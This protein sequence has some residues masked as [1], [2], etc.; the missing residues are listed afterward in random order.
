MILLLFYLSF[1]LVRLPPLLLPLGITTNIVFRVI[2][3]GSFFIL[4]FIKKVQI[5]ISKFIFFSSIFL[6]SQILSVINAI[7]ITNFLYFAEKIV[8]I[9]AFLFISQILLKKENVSKV[10][11][12]ILITLYLN[13][14]IE[15]ILFFS[16]QLTQ[17]LYQIIHP[18]IIHMLSYNL[19]QRNRLFFETS[20]EIFFPLILYFYFFKKEVFQKKIP[21]TFLFMSIFI[22]SFWSNFRDRFVTGIFSILS[23]IYLYK[24]ELKKIK[25]TKIVW[26]LAIFMTIFIIGLAYS[27]A[28][29]G[30]SIVDRIFLQNKQEDVDTL[31]FRGVLASQSIKMFLANPVFGVGLGN[32]YE[33]IPES[34][35]IQRFNFFGDSRVFYEG[36]LLYP[37][38][39]ILQI[40]AETGSVGLFGFMILIIYFI[41][42]DLNII[43]SNQPLAK[44]LIICFWSLLLYALFSPKSPLL[45]YFQFFLLRSLI[46]LVATEF[47]ERN[48]HKRAS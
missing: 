16:P 24:N 39:F 21:L 11:K 15:M 35:K 23:F 18:A 5:K 27:N 22:L 4:I 9:F 17:Y 14:F 29:N 10:L 26:F 7:N 30:F 38:N 42:K 32:F 3:L 31:A 44:T 45:F 2:I 12:I 25:L 43:K 48:N 47:P 36:T 8:T 1:F 13:V 46:E 6:I 37:H 33:Y 40:M 19:E 34:M 20:G 41:K 28:T